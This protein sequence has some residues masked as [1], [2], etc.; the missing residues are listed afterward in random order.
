MEIRGQARLAN[1]HNTNRRYDRHEFKEIVVLPRLFTLPGDLPL[2][3]EPF[4]SKKI[5]LH[6]KQLKSLCLTIF[7]LNMNRDLFSMKRF[8]TEG[9]IF[10]IDEEI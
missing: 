8:M 1:T 3:R 4:S 10:L 6:I 9:R 5:F 7:L 2:S